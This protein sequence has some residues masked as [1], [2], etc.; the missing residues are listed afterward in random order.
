MALL[1]KESI[2]IQEAGTE[3]NKVR[4]KITLNF[5]GYYDVEVPEGK[6]YTFY[7]PAMDLCYSAPTIEEGKKLAKVLPGHSYTIGVK[8]AVNL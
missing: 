2:T 1:Q 3:G 8:S 4:M 5:N 7:I 6:L